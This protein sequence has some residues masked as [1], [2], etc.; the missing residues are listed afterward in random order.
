MQNNPSCVLGILSLDEELNYDYPI[1][2]ERVPGASAEKVLAGDDTLA[3]N[4]IKTGE[5]LINRGASALTANCG[6]TI[7]YQKQLSSTL[8]VPIATSS[9]LL[10][11]YLAA[12]YKDP[13]GII[14]IDSRALKPNDLRY[15]GIEEDDG[16]RFPIIGV[17]HTQTWSSMIPYY[18]ESKY[19]I[20]IVKAD[21]SNAV[22]RL[23]DKYPNVKCILFEC[24]GFPPA[25]EH[26][27]KTFKL[28]VYDYVLVKNLLMA[29]FPGE[30]S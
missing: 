18:D 16:S 22:V 27:R 30:G 25:A 10:L 1:L 5:K 14:T 2:A 29:G 9:L 3:S 13:I 23:L 12:T 24:T 19:D 17:E 11:P 6:F 8:S 20:E 4:Y 15:A 21:L 26:I 28:P 7:R